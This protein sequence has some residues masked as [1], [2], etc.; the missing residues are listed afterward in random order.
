M[1][2][3][4]ADARRALLD[5]ANELWTCN[6]VPHEERAHGIELPENYMN[7]FF[8]GAAD[9]LPDAS[10]FLTRQSQDNMPNNLCGSGGDWTGSQTLCAALSYQNK[11]ANDP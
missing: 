6:R 7:S 1:F 10:A 8:N 2:L 5:A 3:T 9:L 11:C 4:R